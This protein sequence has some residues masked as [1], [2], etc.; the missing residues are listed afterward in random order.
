MDEIIKEYGAGI[1]AALGG[2]FFLIFLGTMYRQGGML[3]TII[4][5]FLTGVCG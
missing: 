2:L 4:V 3:Y 1:L 5:E